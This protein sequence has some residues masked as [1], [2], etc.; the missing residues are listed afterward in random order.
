LSA[1]PEKVETFDF[2]DRLGNEHRI[3]DPD[4]DAG[5]CGRNYPKPCDRE[6]CGGLVHANFGDENYDGYWLYT[7]CDRCGESESGA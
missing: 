2:G 1:E 6:G 7:K 5:W 4:C 3:G